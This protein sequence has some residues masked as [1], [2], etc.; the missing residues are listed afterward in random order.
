L[1][2][3]FTGRTKD[4]SGKLTD[5][6]PG[7]QPSTQQP[8]QST[9]AQDYLSQYVNDLLQQSVLA[10]DPTNLV[11]QTQQAIAQQSS[12]Y[13]ENTDAEDKYYGIRPLLG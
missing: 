10:S 1:E 4:A 13:L 3:A 2:W 5:V 8:S 12:N 6:M 7:G 9:D 11:K